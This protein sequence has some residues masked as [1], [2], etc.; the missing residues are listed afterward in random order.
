MNTQ[1]RFEEKFGI[2][3]ISD[4]SEENHQPAIL[5]FIES[6]KQILRG[7]LSE[8]VRGM[9]KEKINGLYYGKEIDSRDIEALNQALESAAL[10]I[11]S[12]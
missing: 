9:K 1:Q 8:K 3:L 6:E 5:A 10:I 11:E 2:W 7:E 12:E 4:Y